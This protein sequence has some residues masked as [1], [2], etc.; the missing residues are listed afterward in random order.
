[1]WLRNVRDKGKDA[2]TVSQRMH[3]GVALAIGAGKRRVSKKMC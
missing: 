1:M 3:E 2:L